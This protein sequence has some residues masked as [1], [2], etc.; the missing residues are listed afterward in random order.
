MRCWPHQVRIVVIALHFIAGYLHDIRFR[1]V[2]WYFPLATAL[3]FLEEAPRFTTWAQRYA[4]PHFTLAHW[5][6]IHAIGFVYALAFS[7]MV[8]FYPRRPLVFLFL[9][10]CF[11]ESGFNALFHLGASLYFRTYSPGLLTAF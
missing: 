2:I 5:K 3:H 1:E 11:L 9:A 10:L 4:S 8:S 6:R 7:G